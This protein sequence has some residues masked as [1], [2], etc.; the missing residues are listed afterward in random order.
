MNVP[1]YALLGSDL[2]AAGELS[3]LTVEPSEDGRFL[4]VGTS[5]REQRAPSTPRR[6]ALVQMELKTLPEEIEG[7]EY[8][9]DPLWVEVARV[10][11]PRPKRP[12]SREASAAWGPFWSGRRPRESTEFG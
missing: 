10:Q 8:V 7:I 2:A 3:P 1:L 11:L 6:S 4:I 9:G 5:L 12:F